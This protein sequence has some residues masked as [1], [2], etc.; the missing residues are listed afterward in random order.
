MALGLAL[1]AVQPMV[2]ATLHQLTPAARHGEAI[3][4]RS[5]TINASAAVLPL[6][7]G[8]AGAGFGVGMLFS[9]MGLAVGAGSQIVPRLVRVLAARS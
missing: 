4:L 7:F 1:G 2:M 8:L 5:M 6:I 3:A 9:I